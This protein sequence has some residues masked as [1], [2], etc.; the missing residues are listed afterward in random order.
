[1]EW[2]EKDTGGTSAI[3]NVTNARRK[4]ERSQ[5]CVSHL[6]IMWF[7]HHH[8][9]NKAAAGLLLYMTTRNDIKQREEEDATWHAKFWQEVFLPRPNQWWPTTEKNKLHWLSASHGDSNPNL[10]GVRSVIVH[11]LRL[12]PHVDSAILRSASSTARW[13]ATLLCFPT[14]FPEFVVCF[15][16]SASVLTVVNYWSLY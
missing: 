10:L 15:S 13:A 2:C 5:M 6:I 14:L 11:P 7:L 9:L 16:V 3:T 4:K 1:M 12:Q 8:T